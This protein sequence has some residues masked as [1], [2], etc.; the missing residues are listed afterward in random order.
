MNDVLVRTRHFPHRFRLQWLMECWNQ[1]RIF[2]DQ[3]YR[4]QLR[5][6][7]SYDFSYFSIPSFYVFANRYFYQ[8]ESTTEE[9]ADIIS[10]WYLNWNRY[11]HYLIHIFF[12][13]YYTDCTVQLK[14]IKASE[15]LIVCDVLV[16]YIQAV[17]EFSPNSNFKTDIENLY[18]MKIPFKGVFSFY[19]RWNE[20]NYSSKASSEAIYS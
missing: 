18:L 7:N 13:W 14:L 3:G 20:R 10:Q 17:Y 5:F 8:F 2:I 16:G 12:L 1:Q 6:G 11:F 15:I 19:F 4:K 9:E